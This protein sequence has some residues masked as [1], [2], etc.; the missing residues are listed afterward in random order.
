[1]PPNQIQPRTWFVEIRLA[2]S[3]QPSNAN[4]T[5]CIIDI[6]DLSNE[7]CRRIREHVSTAYTSR[8]NA[9][10]LDNMRTEWQDPACSL[11]HFVGVVGF[12]YSMESILDTTMRLWIVHSN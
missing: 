2:L 8:E 4:T 5:L 9:M 11:K 7:D 6:F 3:V 12:V 10:P 1:M